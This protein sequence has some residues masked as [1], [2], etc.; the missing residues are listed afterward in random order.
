MAAEEIDKTVERLFRGLNAAG[1]AC[2]RLFNAK[3]SIPG[4]KEFFERKSRSYESFGFQYDSG[5]IDFAFDADSKCVFCV[6]G[7]YN[8]T[9]S[10]E[11]LTCAIFKDGREYVASAGKASFKTDDIIYGYQGIL[12]AELPVVGSKDKLAEMIVKVRGKQVHFDIPLE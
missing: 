5:V 10:D 7:Y 6:L 4:F 2:E 9:G 3:T 8:K 1:K 11:S 12:L